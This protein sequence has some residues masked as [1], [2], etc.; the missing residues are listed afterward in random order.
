MRLRKSDL[1]V[2]LGWTLSFLSALLLLSLVVW[3]RK[4]ASACACVNIGQISQTSL[5]WQIW[6]GLIET[7]TSFSLMRDTSGNTHTHTHTRTRRLTCLINSTI[8]NIFC[9]IRRAT[10]SSLCLLDDRF[11]SSSSSNEQ[12]EDCRLIDGND[13]IHTTRVN[14]NGQCQHD[15]TIDHAN[16]NL[17]TMKIWIE[18]CWS[19][20]YDGRM[21]CIHVTF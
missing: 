9:N 7:N 12:I 19:S 8:R 1:R 2:Q 6:F 17:V 21:W 5:M 3:I 16:V 13:D 15:W 11:F 18:P 20:K 10:Q 4:W 14:N